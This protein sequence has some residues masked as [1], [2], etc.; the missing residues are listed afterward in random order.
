MRSEGNSLYLNLLVDSIKA[1][2]ATRPLNPDQPRSLS[3]S[4][5]QANF[6]ALPSHDHAFIQSV[7]SVVPEGL[8][9]VF[10]RRLSCLP[11]AHVIVLKVRPASQIHEIRDNW[12][13]MAHCSLSMMAV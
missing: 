12:D 11:R 5:R 10:S 9:E 7:A 4:T 2:L 13:S 1:L 8:Q 3:H 6:C